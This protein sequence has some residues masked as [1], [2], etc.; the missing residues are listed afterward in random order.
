MSGQVATGSPGLPLAAPSTFPPRRAACPSAPPPLPACGSAP[1]G[2][3]VCFTYASSP[4][5]FMGLHIVRQD[6]RGLPGEWRGRGRSRGPLTET[7]QVPAGESR[8]SVSEPTTDTID[9]GPRPPPPPSPRGTATGA[10]CDRRPSGTWRGDGA[11]VAES[12][13]R[14]RTARFSTRLLSRHEY[15][16]CFIGWELRGPTSEETH[17]ARLVIA[18]T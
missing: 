3:P 4:R 11:V 15:A 2:W 17:P 8:G 9:T 10:T 16:E 7:A 14:V 5:L 13:L 6:V 18:S 1:P 12:L